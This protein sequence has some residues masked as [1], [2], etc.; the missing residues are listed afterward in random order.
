MHVQNAGVVPKKTSNTGITVPPDDLAMRL[1][2]DLGGGQI[3][4][5]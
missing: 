4:L 2:S 3:A 1:S 5:P